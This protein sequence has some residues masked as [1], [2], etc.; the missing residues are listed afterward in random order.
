MEQ[1]LK[2]V[3][4]WLPANNQIQRIMER[5]SFVE[6]GGRTIYRLGRRIV[7]YRDGYRVYFGKP[8]DVTRNTFDALSE[9]IAHEYCLKVCERKKWE[10]VKCSNPVAY[11]AHRVLNALA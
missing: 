5:I 11:N 6:K 7:C 9:N 2:L 4:S 10:R 8:S 1:S 3:A